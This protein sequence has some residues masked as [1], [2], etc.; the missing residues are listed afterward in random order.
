M[1]FFSS[2]ANLKAIMETKNRN[3]LIGGTVAL[4][5][6]SALM[7]KSA[8]RKIPRGVSSVRPFDVNRYAGKWY[9]IARLDI[10]QER[11]LNNTTAD[12]SLNDGA[13]HVLNRGYDAGREKWKEAT[14]IAKFVNAEDEA[15]LKVSFFGPFYSGYNVIAIDPH[16]ICNG[17]QPCT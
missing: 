13:I 8:G 2:A 6:V 15:R 17:K 1:M 11:G 10:K 14:A 3:L 5:A 16:V 12:Y 7:L 9:E 4:A